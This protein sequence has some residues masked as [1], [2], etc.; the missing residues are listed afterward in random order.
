MPDTLYFK[1]NLNEI[2]N[3]AEK[4]SKNDKIAVV[5]MDY[6]MPEM[7]GIEV[8]EQISLPCVEKIMLTSMADEKLAVQA[9]NRGLI[10]RYIP[11]QDPNLILLINE[12]IEVGRRN[13]FQR[14]TQTLYNIMTGDEQETALTDPIFIQFFKQLKEKLNAKEHYLLDSTGSFLFINADKVRHKLSTYTKEQ[15]QSLLETLPPQHRSVEI[16]KGRQLYH[17]LLGPAFTPCQEL[18]KMKDSSWT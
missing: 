10:N 18:R 11:K 6:Q 5:F 8:F 2:K 15:F 7:N 12:A 9:F 4:P 3:Y 13:Y 14:S 17:C 1:A 16:I